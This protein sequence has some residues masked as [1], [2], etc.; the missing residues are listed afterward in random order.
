MSKFMQNGND[1]DED[2]EEIPSEF[3]T[4]RPTLGSQY[5]TDNP[6]HHI[7]ASL[8]GQHKR[9]KLRE[10]TQPDNFLLKT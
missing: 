7:N 4:G 1:S 6:R 2:M 9:P 10:K 8:Q 5:N 3:E